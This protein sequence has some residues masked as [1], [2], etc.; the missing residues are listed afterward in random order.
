V[1]LTIAQF[2]ERSGIAE[3]LVR[4]LLEAGR[5]PVL[6]GVS[7]V[8]IPE[9]AIERLEAEAMRRP[10]K[11]RAPATED[12]KVPATARRTRTSTVSP[13]PTPSRAATRPTA[14][15][16]LNPLVRDPSDELGIWHQRLRDRRTACGLR[17]G[18]AWPSGKRRVPRCI[19]CAMVGA[20]PGLEE[21][22]RRRE[23]PIVAGW[24]IDR[25]WREKHPDLAHKVDEAL[26]R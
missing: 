16:R 9:R 25:D 26:R 12:E 17:I 5:I 20:L 18:T 23:I 1:F 8:L 6:A 10:P 19:V 7:E 2:A 3:P 21:I 14:P 11:P 24:I 4:E 13:T 15:P 22:W